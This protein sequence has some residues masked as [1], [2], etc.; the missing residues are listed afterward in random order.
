MPPVE[1]IK[2]KRAGT[3]LRACNHD[4]VPGFTLFAPHD[5]Q[6]EVYL[7]DLQGKFNN[8]VFCAY[9]YSAEEIARARATGDAL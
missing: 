4:R 6:G 5:G 2:L 9:R 7:I 1:Q 3:G 8:R